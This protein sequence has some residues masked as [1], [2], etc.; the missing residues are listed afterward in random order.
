[1][2]FESPLM[3]LVP[4]SAVTGHG[5]VNAHDEPDKYSDKQVPQLTMGCGE[6]PEVDHNPYYTL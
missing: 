4:S 5:H 1:M 2:G 3:L 6:Y